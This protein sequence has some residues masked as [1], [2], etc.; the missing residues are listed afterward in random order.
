MESGVNTKENSFYG[1]HMASQ[2]ILPSLFLC[3]ITHT[4]TRNIMKNTKRERN[5]I[6][7]G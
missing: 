2:Q 5:K 6:N 7:S 3:D 4:H 1:K